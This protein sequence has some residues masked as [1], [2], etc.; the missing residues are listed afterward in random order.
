M[1]YPEIAGAHA[2]HFGLDTTL[3]PISCDTCHTGLGSGTQAHYDRA[4]ARPGKDALRVPPGDVA[5]VTTYDAQ[6]GAPS[7]DNAA[8]TCTNVSCHGGQ[9]TPDWQTGTIDVNTQCTN[10]HAFGT[11]QFN[12]YSSG[13]HD[14]HVNALGFFCTVCHNTTT[15][16]V[17]HHT[18]LSTPA[19]EGPASATVGGGTTSVSSYIAPT[20][21]SVCH[22]SPGRTW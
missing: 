18:A 4:N 13:Q 7:F 14:R 11:T 1:A 10:C 12:S 5:F 21:I 20:C 15:L 17:N 6:S 3:T 9:T 16:A 22:P 8:L 2:V 19:L